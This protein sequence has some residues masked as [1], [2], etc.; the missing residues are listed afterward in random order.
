MTASNALNWLRNN[1]NYVENIGI[2]LSAGTFSIQG[3]NGSALSST[4]AGYVTIGS[5]VTPGKLI[6]I[7]ITANQTFV[8]DSGTSTIAGNLF[9]FGASDTVTGVDVP[10]YIYAVINDTDTAISFMISRT[11]GMTLSPASANIGKTGS[12]VADTGFSFFALDNPTVTDYDSNPCSLIGSFRMR[13]TTAPG[14]WTVQTL[15]TSDGIGQFQEG[16]IF[17][18]PPA[19]MGASTNSHWLANGGTAPAWSTASNYS[20]TYTL[21][22]NGYITINYIIT[23]DPSTNGVGA[24]TGKVII[25]FITNTAAN[26]IAG[27]GHLGTT[28][29]SIL[30]CGPQ[31][32]QNYMVFTYNSNAS[33]GIVQNQDITAATFTDM[34]TNL[35]YFITRS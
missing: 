20:Y 11:P 10:F 7:R 33:D 14:D 31:A 18:F 19:V 32:G 34:Q 29:A 16:T 35:N 17:T 9:G 24:V 21:T 15:T 12:A 23:G 13:L 3:G 2:G 26:M 4:N 30:S 8:D 5:K 6:A 1:P 25:P 28:L 22:K 27:T